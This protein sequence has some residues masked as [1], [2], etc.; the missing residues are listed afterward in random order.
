MQTRTIILSGIVLTLIAVSIEWRK[1]LGPSSIP[2]GTTATVPPLEPG[3]RTRQL[4]PAVA[5][6]EP[7]EI[8]LLPEAVEIAA[9]LNT[10]ETT[11][12]DDLETVELLV[13][14]FRRSNGGANPAGGENDEIVRQLTGHND[15]GFAVLPLKHPAISPGGR[16][17]DRWGRPYYFHP[18][19]RDVLGLRSGG[20][21]GRLFTADDVILE[22]AT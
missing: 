17:L 11:P 2:G 7:A 1:V 21:D 13:S 16:L 9:R 8:V 19:S 5:R 6:K 22:P 10:S 3:K 4:P 12:A 18:I 15:K 20:P 14:I